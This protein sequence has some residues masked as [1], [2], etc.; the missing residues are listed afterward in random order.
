MKHFLYGY[1]ITLLFSVMALAAQNCHSITDRYCDG[2]PFISEHGIKSSIEIGTNGESVY[3]IK[4]KSSSD[5]DDQFYCPES[6]CTCT[7]DIKYL[8]FEGNSALIKKINQKEKQEANES[9]CS[10]NEES[11]VRR[12]DFV[13]TSN[14]FI[15]TAIFNMQYCR[16]CGGG[17]HGNTSLSTYNVAT[18]QKYIL[19]DIMDSKDLSK[20]RK[21]L[22]ILFIK[23]YVSEDPI[24]YVKK[25][26]QEDINS[27]VNLDLDLYVENDKIYI[28]INDFILGCSEGSFYPLPIPK[29]YIRPT[30][31]KILGA[32]K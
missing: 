26:L 18:G 17:C 24:G 14:S 25:F 12:P 8:H 23:N 7:A 15:S 19:S 6:K 9:E 2:T 11:V 5:I 31:L 28:N 10:I 1:L 16:E 27:T 29:K 13:Y 22:K 30:F 21:D 32:T 20:L 3:E 4:H